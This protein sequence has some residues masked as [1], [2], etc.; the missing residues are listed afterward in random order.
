ML[1]HCILTLWTELKCR[2]CKSKKVRLLSYQ[3][4]YICDDCQQL[5]WQVGGT[6][7]EMVVDEVDQQ[8]NVLR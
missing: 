2:Y 8:T 1:T 3:S 7:R 6:E 5:L 4:Y